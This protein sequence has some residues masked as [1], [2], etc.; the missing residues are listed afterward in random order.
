MDL[1]DIERV[2]ILRGPQGRL[3]G[4]NT[5]GGAINMISKKPGDEAGASIFSFNG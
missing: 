5:I 4:K 1:V 3:Y 2:E